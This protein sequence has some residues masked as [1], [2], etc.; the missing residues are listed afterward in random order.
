MI[1]LITFV[2]GKNFKNMTHHTESRHA[3]GDPGTTA[4][5]GTFGTCKAGALLLARRSE[6]AMPSGENASGNREER[7]R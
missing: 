4:A 7:I 1:I 6:D 3:G 5:T 2:P